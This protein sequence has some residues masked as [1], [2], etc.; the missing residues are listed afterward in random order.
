MYFKKKKT[1]AYHVNFSCTIS[2]DDE[3]AKYVTHSFSM[4]QFAMAKM[5]S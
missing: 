2:L 1:A 3:K 4:T 5:P